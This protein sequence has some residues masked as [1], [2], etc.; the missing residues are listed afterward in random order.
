MANIITVLK[1]KH[2]NARPDQ[3]KNVNLNMYIINFFILNVVKYLASQGNTFPSNLFED[4]HMLY[5][6][7]TTLLPYSLFIHGKGAEDEESPKKQI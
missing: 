3:M 6:D 1:Y 4:I 7:T 5:Q 2:K